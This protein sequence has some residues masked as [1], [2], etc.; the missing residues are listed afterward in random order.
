MV[1]KLWLLMLLGGVLDSGMAMSAAGIRVTADKKVMVLGE[2]LLVQIRAEDP[3][4]PLGSINL[5]KLKQD[6]NVYSISSNVQTQA[7]KG[8]RVKVETLSLTLYPLRTGILRLPEFSYMGSKGRALAVMVNES[9]KHI[10]RVIFKAALDTPRP[11]VRQA[12]T[13]TLDIYDDGNLLWTSP[14]D[15]VA[16]GAHQRKLA[17]SRRDEIVEGIR[18]TVHRHAWALMPLREG[19]MKIEFPLLDA[20]R[21]G[22]RLRYAVAPLWLDAAAVPAYLPVHVP[23]GKIEVAAESLPPEI[24]LERPVNWSFTVKGAG[25]SSEGLS[26]MLTTIRSSAALQF[27]PAT[28]SSASSERAV[29]AEQTLQVTLPFVPKQS[30]VVNLPDINL[31][32]YDTTSSRVESVFIPGNR[33]NVFNPLWR[34]AQKIALGLI[35][36]ASGV[37]LVYCLFKKFLRDEKKRKHLRIIGSAVNADELRR[38]LLNFEVH[39]ALHPCRTLQEWLRHIK[40]AYYTDDKLAE[41]VQKLSSAQYGSQEN[42]ENISDLSKVSA[43]LLKNLR[44]KKIGSFSIVRM[45]SWKSWFSKS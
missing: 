16:T 23:V 44:A 42:G 10:S 38:A 19:G 25:I 36:L 37:F 20:S 15:V 17:E 31:S 22:S 21:L 8:H 30:G 5:D 12:A 4:K 2:P 14:G 45:V 3:R 18:Y 43:K 6:F 28:I 24:A 9:G 40:L 26:K 32:Y 1:K 27:Y 29:S 33:I 7:I 35:L 13:L 11:Q 34:T 41:V 39:T